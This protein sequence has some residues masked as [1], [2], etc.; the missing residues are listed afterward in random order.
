MSKFGLKTQY[1]Q[2]N[3]KFGSS[4]NLT[5]QNS[6]VVLTFFVLKGKH[7]FWANLVK[8]NKIVTLN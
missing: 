2:F 1:C 3:L 7:P 4:N 5:M 8:K 6:M